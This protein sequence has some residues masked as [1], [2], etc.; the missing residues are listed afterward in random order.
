MNKQKFRPQFAPRPTKT[1]LVTAAK[2]Q[3]KADEERT[4]EE[5]PENAPVGV[6]ATSPEEADLPPAKTNDVAA[7]SATKLDEPPVE[8][9][10]A[11]ASPVITQTAPRVPKGTDSA[12][13]YTLGKKYNP[14]TDRNSETW[15]KIC[16]ALAEGPKTMKELTEVVKGHGDFLGYM[17]RGGHIVPHVPTAAV[18]G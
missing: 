11:A 10:P 3:V 7:G 17:T 12:G 15:G 14:K 13:Q 8:T 18:S 16:K 4:P 2:V 9:A 5:G 6:G 1:A